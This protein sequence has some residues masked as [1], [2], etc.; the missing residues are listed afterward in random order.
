MILED[1]EFLDFLEFLNSGVLECVAFSA[2]FVTIG[3]ELAR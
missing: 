3:T 2:A 1:L